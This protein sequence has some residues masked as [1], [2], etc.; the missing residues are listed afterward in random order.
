MDVIQYVKDNYPYTNMQNAIRVNQVLDIY[1]RAKTGK[2]RT[3]SSR[4]AKATTNT[5]VA[6]IAS[7]VTQPIARD[8]R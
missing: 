2:T 1:K 4:A 8:T 6:A 3:G 5:K 7:A